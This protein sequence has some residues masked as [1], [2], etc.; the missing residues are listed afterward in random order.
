MER[1]ILI[2]VVSDI[3]IT[4]HQLRLDCTTQNLPL[5]SDKE[6]IV[7]LSKEWHEHTPSRQL[8]T[9]EGRGS[10][11]ASIDRFHVQIGQTRSIPQTN[12]TV[13]HPAELDDQ[14]IQTRQKGLAYTSSDNPVPIT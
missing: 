11:R 7:T 8:V 13:R 9:Q 14:L 12:L 5:S 1:I 2:L 3:A 6:N 10:L 4:A